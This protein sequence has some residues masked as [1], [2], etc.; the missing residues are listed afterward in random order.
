[1]ISVVIPALNEEKYIKS[2]LLSLKR[3]SLHNHET[4]VVD[5]GSTDRTI[6]IAKELADKVIIE[7]VSPVGAARNLGAENAR[8]DII[9]FLDADTI[10][11]RGWTE[12]IQ[13][14]MSEDNVVGVTG[15]TFPVG[16][17][18]FDR[19][20]Y[21]MSTDYLQRFLIT[22][23]L[24]HIPGFNCAYR[25]DAFFSVEGFDEHRVTHEDMLLSMDL[26]EAGKILY[27]PNML[28]FTSL[29]RIDKYG[30]DQIIP[31]YVSNFFLTLLFDKSSEN[32]Y[33]V[34]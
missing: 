22:L 18:D 25:K 6:E 19:L 1:L 2:C 30:Y 3:Q 32:Y 4:I 33:P 7:A 26:K 13:R 20:V 9:A 21:R 29:R 12:A 31:L 27:N 16:G 5:G 23:K 8:G 10:A 24:P 17:K 11:S 34:R 28:A 15:P 14:S